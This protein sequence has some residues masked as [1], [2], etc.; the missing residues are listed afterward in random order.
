MEQE[1][2]KYIERV[3]REF[4]DGKVIIGASLLRIDGKVIT[5]HYAGIEDANPNLLARESLSAK[6]RRGNMFPALG[7]LILSITM[8]EKMCVGLA[9]VNEDQY[10]QLISKPGVSL[11]TFGTK[12]EKISKKLR[13]SN[14]RV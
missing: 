6:R 7:R 8:Y 9:S 13:A 11:L 3:V 10:I 14:I 2:Q 5:S 1:K 12:L 4:V